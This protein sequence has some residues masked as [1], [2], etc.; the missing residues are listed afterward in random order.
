MLVG[1]TQNNKKILAQ[2][3]DKDNKYICPFCKN[4]LILKKGK[5]RKAH[6]AHYINECKFGD[7]YK[8]AESE[9]HRK[10]K[11]I[12]YDYF[13][14][15]GAYVEL[16]KFFK[17][18]IAD[19]Y[20]EINNK[21]FVIEIQ[22]SPL[23]EEIFLKRMKFYT[24]NNIPVLWIIAPSTIEKQI[25]HNTDYEYFHLSEWLKNITKIYFGYLYTFNFNSKKI[26]LISLEN[27]YVYVDYN[28]YLEVGGYSKKLKNRKTYEIISDFDIIKDF[29]I[30]EYKGKANKFLIYE[31]NLFKKNFKRKKYSDYL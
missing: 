2:E 8:E 18:A 19:I 15:I 9:E 22:K 31:A 29:K 3:A 30:N 1:M 7:L 10:I 20:V 23:K 6:F 17:E 11:Y 13:K 4:K 25:R 16:E 26:D 5:V 14:K 24:K 12:L 27:K 21:N 28:D